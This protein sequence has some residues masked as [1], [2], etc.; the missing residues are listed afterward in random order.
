MINNNFINI[1]KEAFH[2]KYEIEI[3]RDHIVVKQSEHVRRAKIAQILEDCHLNPIIPDERVD[4][5]LVFTL[6]PYAAP[7]FFVFMKPEERAWGLIRQEIPFAAKHKQSLGFLKKHWEK[8]CNQH[9]P[10]N[11]LC[12]N[13][14]DSI[15]RPGRALDLGCGYGVRTKY[16][17]RKGW[18][19]DAVDMTPA[20]VQKLRSDVAGDFVGRL[21][22]INAKAEEFDFSQ[23]YDLILA[24]DVLFYT[25]PAQFRELW[26]KIHD[27]LNEQGLFLGSLVKQV[28]NPLFQDM[29]S[30][31][32]VWFIEDI[33]H[34]RA[35]L[36]NYKIIEC[37]YY[38]NHEQL[39]YPA[40]F[41]FMAQK[42]N[43]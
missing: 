34:V 31:R 33:R 23:K 12:Q 2:E 10:I 5:N 16:L 6:T 7:S 11:P 29:L 40:E 9:Q 30:M 19:V 37:D 27:A 8:T 36:N 14:I 4:G 41:E 26:N 42:F 24:Y 17:L 20:I 3:N 15:V 39:R 21:N 38:L 18:T 1:I 22:L 32:G 43:S 25:D 13:A 35:L 28:R